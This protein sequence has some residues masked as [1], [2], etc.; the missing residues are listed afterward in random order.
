MHTRRLS[1][2]IATLGLIFTGC[3]AEDPK[4]LD[5]DINVIVKD[6]RTVPVESVIAEDETIDWETELT[7]VELI[8]EASCLPEGRADFCASLNN[9][10]CG[11]NADI[12]RSVWGPDH[13]MEMGESFQRCEAYS[14]RQIAEYNTRKAL[15]AEGGGYWTDGNV[16][17]PA[18]LQPYE[19]S[20][21]CANPS[22]TNTGL[23]E[24]VMADVQSC[25][26]QAWV[27]YLECKD[28]AAHCLE[29]YTG[30]E[31]SE[32]ISDECGEATFT[33][34]DE[35]TERVYQA[36]AAEL[37][38][39]DS[40]YEPYVFSYY[41]GTCMAESEY[42]D[43]TD[44]YWLYLNGLREYI[45]ENVLDSSKNSSPTVSDF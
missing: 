25:S 29:D 15:C 19:G 22:Y 34:Y 44:E 32:C 2:T 13:P 42:D 43:V 3:L 39:L 30:D 45:P 6:V 31:I 27:E 8:D 14:C 21:T 41:T 38:D 17:S 28:K 26:D 16:F 24:G 36:N 35:C 12:C 7:D 18:L 33:Y 37:D 11:L 5:R 9:Y 23:L 40:N 4:G 10:E 20:C 1:I